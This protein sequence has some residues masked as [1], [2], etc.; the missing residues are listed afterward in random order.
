MIP[1]GFMLDRLR[2]LSA[3]AGVGEYGKDSR[4]WTTDQQAQGLFE[5]EPG[6]NQTTV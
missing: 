5:V 3:N 1:I 6:I 2:I 4:A